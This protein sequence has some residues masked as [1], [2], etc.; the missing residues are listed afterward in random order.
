MRKTLWGL[1]GL[2]LLLDIQVPLSPVL[3]HFQVHNPHGWS[4]VLLFTQVFCEIVIMV[5]ATAFWYL[6]LYRCMTSKR[7]T[8]LGKVVWGLIFLFGAWWGSQVFYL[9]V[10]RRGPLIEVDPVWR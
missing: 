6:M 10:F 7:L 4:S 1:I 8:V 9:I 5:G 3:V 2:S